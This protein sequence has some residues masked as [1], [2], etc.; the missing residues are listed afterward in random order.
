[1]HYD[2]LNKRDSIIDAETDFWFGDP[3]YVVPDDHWDALCANW[4]TYEKANPQE[5]HY[6]ARVEHE[7]TGLCFYTWSTAFG[8]GTYELHV[9]DNVVAKLCVDAGCLSA[10]P[11]RLLE[12][13]KEQGIIGEY[14]DLG[15]VVSADKLH[16][17]LFTDSGDMFW[18]K[19]T[20]PTGGMD[21]G[22]SDE[23]DPYDE[24]CCDPFYA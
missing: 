16:G 17:E 21:E 3:C 20:L 18:G 23:H 11:V 1:M 9:D 13:W 6:I 24:E 15:H 10:I 8:D 22:W 19:V 4:Q 14:E 2:K 12:Y 5:R 7:P